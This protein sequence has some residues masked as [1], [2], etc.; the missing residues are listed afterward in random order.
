MATF[1]IEALLAPVSE[2]EPGGPNLEYDRE[3]QNMDRLSQGKPERQMGDQVM[4]G[5][6]PDWKGVK[7]AAQALLLRSKDLRVAIHLTKAGLRLAGVSGFAD[8][9]HLVREL[10]ERFWDG[11]HPRLDA[12][13]DNDPTMRVNT[14]A[15]L[16]DS[17]TLGAL[18]STPLLTSKVL[19]KFSLRDVLVASGEV[20]PTPDQ[21]PLTMATIEAISDSV[22]M[23]VLMAVTNAVSSAREDVMSIEALVGDKV[24]ASQSA[25]LSRLSTTLEQA[26]KL[27][28]SRVEHR[29]PI[30]ELPADDT[31]E[32][33]MTQ[34]D[35]DGSGA[36]AKGG[37]TGAIRTRD[38]V[39]RVL[40]L[41]AAYYQRAEPSSPVPILLAR[42][43]RLAKM[44]F[45][46]IVKDMAPDA[47]SQI[48]LIRGPTDEG[49]GGSSS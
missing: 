20:P 7:Q 8:G 13:D 31:S 2:A 47:M 40:D 26:R 12:D 25:N 1:D 19:G 16:A 22:D 5:E 41:I 49:G 17:P 27:L 36:P 9:I 32:I 48:E 3:F 38:D 33:P 23:D 21:P 42:A 34:G 11:V 37:G 30:A 18:R 10:L 29:T 44:T 14:L 4:P 24:G 46:D 15:S 6:D 45:V 39:V 43:K 28:A 35:G